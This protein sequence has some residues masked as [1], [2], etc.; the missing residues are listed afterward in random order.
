MQAKSTGI[1]MYGHKL[2]IFTLFSPDFTLFSLFLPRSRKGGFGGKTRAW[3]ARTLNK[4]P[5][6]DQRNIIE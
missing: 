3:V 2:G 1:F 4:Q 5:T 6:N